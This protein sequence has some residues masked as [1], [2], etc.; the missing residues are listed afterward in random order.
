[1]VCM[2]YRVTRIPQAVTGWLRDLAASE[3]Y[4]Q[5]KAQKDKAINATWKQFSH[6]P[7]APVH[8]S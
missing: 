5:L 2:I 6:S 3:E 4:N 1:M 7:V 8:I